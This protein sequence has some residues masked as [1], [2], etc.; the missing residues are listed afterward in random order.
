MI[1][2]PLLFY[3]IIIIKDCRNNLWL[4]LFFQSV[5]RR[6]IKDMHNDQPVKLYHT[7]PMDGLYVP[8]VKTKVYFNYF[9][10]R[11]M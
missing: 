7:R 4:N 10:S 2:E 1:V 3:V 8:S 5:A 6:V 11:S 9:W